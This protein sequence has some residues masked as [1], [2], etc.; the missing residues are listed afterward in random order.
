MVNNHGGKRP[1]SGRKPSSDTEKR[2]SFSV[3]IPESLV[4][5]V[6]AF[7]QSRDCSMNQYIIDSIKMRL[8]K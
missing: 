6:Q 7:C 2:K 1:G 5:R 4:E 8:N 3:S